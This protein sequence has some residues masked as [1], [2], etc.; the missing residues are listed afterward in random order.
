M[1]RLSGVERLHAAAGTGAMALHPRD[2]GG[3]RGIGLEDGGVKLIHEIVHLPR[4]GNGLGH[5]GRVVVHGFLAC[6]VEFLPF[7]GRDHIGIVDHG[8]GGRLLRLRGRKRDSRSGVGD[9]RGLSQ[10]GEDEGR[11]KS[12][13]EEESFHGRRS[14]MGRSDRGGGGCGRW[15]M[16]RR[17]GWC[18]VLAHGFELG[19]DGGDL[20]VGRDGGG[21]DVLFLLGHLAHEGLILGGEI[22]VGG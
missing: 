14:L 16:H 2:N 13:L 19:D 3:D 1:R 5:K 20:G 22:G 9:G 6:P 21:V 7:R 17:R 11:G 18:V 15:H 10:G 8:K 4:Q 12:E